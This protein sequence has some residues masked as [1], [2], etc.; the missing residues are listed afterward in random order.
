M[1]GLVFV[2]NDQNEG[3]LT[4]AL[5]FIARLALLLCGMKTRPALGPKGVIKE[6]N[7]MSLQLCSMSKSEIFYLLPYTCSSTCTC[8]CTCTVVG[9]T[10]KRIGFYDRILCKVLR[11]S[12]AEF[13]SG[14][15]TAI[16]HRRSITERKRIH[17]SFSSFCTATWCRG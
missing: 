4:M 17:C 7:L 15:H 2:C 13:L 16:V 5:I 9:H 3:L 14:G 8:T 11:Y 1:F 10:D 12:F 6:Q